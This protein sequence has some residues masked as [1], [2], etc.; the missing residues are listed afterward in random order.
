MEQRENKGRGIFYGVIGVATLIVAIIGAT[1]AYFTAVA[2][3]DEDAVNTSSAVIGLSYTDDNTGIRGTLI[4]AAPAVV[5]QYAGIANSSCKD[6]NNYNVCSVY[7]FTVENTSE[8]AVTMH[9]SAAVSTATMNDMYYRIIKV[10]KNGTPTFTLPADLANDATSSSV[11][12]AATKQSTTSLASS[13]T[14]LDESYASGDAYD[15]YIVMWIAETGVAQTPGGSF[16][17]TLTVEAADA[18]GIR[19]SRVSGSMFAGEF[20]NTTGTATNGN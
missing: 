2:S 5:S 8:T 4:P 1:F 17:A 7:K 9:F 13:I 20:G 15:Y 19:M 14:A 10:A 12:V 16:A 18:N 6:A 11:V 3:S